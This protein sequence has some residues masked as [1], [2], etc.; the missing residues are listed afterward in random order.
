V[1][2]RMCVMSRSV[3][4][5]VCVRVCVRGSVFVMMCVCGCV[6]CCVVYVCVC[7]CVCLTERGDQPKSE[8]KVCDD[9]RCTLCVCV[10]DIIVCVYDDDQCDVFVYC[11]CVC[12]HRAKDFLYNQRRNQPESQRLLCSN[13]SIM[14]VCV[15]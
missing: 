10:C 3:C 8:S 11:V 12:G 4:V 6:L 15:H 5:I 7:V 1:C 9:T 13:V 14:Y 2:N